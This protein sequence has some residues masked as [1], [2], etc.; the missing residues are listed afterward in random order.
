M[1][2]NYE[3]VGMFFLKLFFKKMHFYILHNLEIITNIQT[4]MGIRCPA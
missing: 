4:I 1:W 3:C 2:N